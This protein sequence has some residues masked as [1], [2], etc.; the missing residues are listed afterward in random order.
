MVWPRVLWIR[1]E[2]R[3][4]AAP[5]I[6]PVFGPAFGGAMPVPPQLKPK[7]AFL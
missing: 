1:A 4:T 6:G 5:L 3:P 7:E 2:L